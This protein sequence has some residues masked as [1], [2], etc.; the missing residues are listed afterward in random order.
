MF[1]QL[2]PENSRGSLGEIN[3]CAG[4]RMDNLLGEWEAV[5]VQNAVEFR[6]LLWW[7]ATRSHRSL[8]TVVASAFFPF[9]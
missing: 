6:R 2:K 1:E 5:V 4:E 7:L 3:D 9:G 8:A